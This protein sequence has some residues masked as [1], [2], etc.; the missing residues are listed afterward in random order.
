M[1]K[2]H[3]WHSRPRLCKGSPDLRIL[4]T[5]ICN[6]QVLRPV[7]FFLDYPGYI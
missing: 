1:L 4:P 7:P 5:A 6:L 3:M 2:K